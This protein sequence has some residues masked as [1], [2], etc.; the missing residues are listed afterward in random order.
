MNCTTCSSRLHDY[1]DGTLSP[2]EIRAYEAHLASCA[3]GRNA[4]G[5][6]RQLRAVTDQLP[7][8]IAP[9]RDLWR[10]LQQSI[11]GNVAPRATSAPV[12]AGPFGGR[13][14]FEV[15]QEPSPQFLQWLAPLGMAAAIALLA[16]FAERQILPRNSTG[17][18]VAAL[19]GT[20]RVDARD[21]RDDTR[22]RVG[23][24]LV[25]DEAARAKVV[26][27]N[28]GEV[29]VEP[30]SRVRVVG[31]AATDHRLELA[32]GTLNAMIWAPPRLFFVNT[33][34]ATAVDLGCAYTLKVDDE[35]NGELEVT[36]G[37]VALEDRG[38]ESIL[39]TGMMCLTRRGV[40]PGTPFSVEA[41]GN[42]R[43]SLRRFD[44]EGSD[45]DAALRDILAQARPEDSI[46]LWHLLDRTQ[47][48]ARAAVY[49]RLAHY[50]PPPATVT[51][52][53]ILAGNTTMRRAWGEHLGI[54][55]F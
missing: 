45:K 16:T 9:S 25:T 55:R 12:I 1:V 4:V 21:V 42:L 22:M 19:A 50:S 3:E 44:F 6:L 54:D 53:G 27:G 49:D 11:S 51:R 39:R 35:G 5:A 38:R 31:M 14:R 17:W 7:R 30:N 24:W 48:T 29:S 36:L 33:P 37:F 43:E 10:E 34:S 40:G 20:P 32:Q 15:S 13:S 8:E 2:D 18:S 23:Q 26:V 47:G 46:T 41:P 52:E 28:I